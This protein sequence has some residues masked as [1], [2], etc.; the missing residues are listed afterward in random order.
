MI[1]TR[2]ATGEIAWNNDPELYSKTSAM[3][4][5]DRR[6]LTRLSPSAPPGR[7]SSLTA[8]SGFAFWNAA[9]AVSASLTLFW[10]LLVRN[11]IWVFPDVSPSLE[12]SEPALQ[13]AIDSAPAIRAAAVA[14]LRRREVLGLM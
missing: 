14:T 6:V 9:I 10:S 11:V 3:S 12:P 8:M 5:V 7:V 2:F 13:A 4:P 1:G